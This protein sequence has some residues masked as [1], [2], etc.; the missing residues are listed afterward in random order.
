MIK[1]GNLL[2]SSNPDQRRDTEL[3]RTMDIGRIITLARDSKLLFQSEMPAFLDLSIPNIS[4]KISK[5]SPPRI[6]SIREIFDTLGRLQETT[7]NEHGCVLYYDAFGNS[8]VKEI[9]EGEPSFVSVSIPRSRD[10]KFQ[11]R[12]HSADASAQMPML[13]IHSHPGQGPLH[14]GDFDTLLSLNTPLLGEG[15]I[16]NGEIDL[17]MLT[18]S[19]FIQHRE[20]DKFQCEVD[21]W[22]HHFKH[23]YAEELARKEYGHYR[24]TM[25]AWCKQHGLA[26]YTSRGVTSENRLRLV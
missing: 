1:E 14:F 6:V 18:Y 10:H 13:L 19:F 4:L 2:A 25:I 3:S 24:R 5:D 12:Y 9:R 8:Y 23:L 16:G 7:G 22:E 20:L 17:A 21:Y 26:W 11:G 15:V